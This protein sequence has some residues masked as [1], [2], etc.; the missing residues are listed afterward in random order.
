[1]LQWGEGTLTVQPL[2][3]DTL[4]VC[5]QGG[6]PSEALETPAPVQ[7]SGAAHLWAVREALRSAPVSDTLVVVAPTGLCGGSFLSP[8]DPSERCSL[9]N[10]VD[11]C[12]VLIDFPACFLTAV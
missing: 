12:I 9:C 11:L 8:V 3:L 2:T 1:M 7:V 10:F 6:F 5:L 4:A